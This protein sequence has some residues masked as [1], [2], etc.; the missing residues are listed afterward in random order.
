MTITSPKHSSNR[1]FSMIELLVTLTVVGIL[2]AVALPNL[3]DMVKSNAVAAQSNHFSTTIN[4]ARSEAVKRNLN[5]FIC[6]RDGSACTT[7][8]EWEDGWIVFADING[9]NALDAGEE[10]SLIDGLTTNYTL[11]SSVTSLDWLAF[12]SDGRAQSNASVF[13][14]V[15]FTL[16]PPGPA[17][18]P[19][20][21]RIITM[22]SV[23]RTS[24]AKGKV[25]D[26]CP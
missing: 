16:C 15:N 11:R 19:T 9:N 22:N 24:L 7:S 3:S 6:V 26:T 20:D 25:T 13:T 8:G 18:N 23:G 10:I 4:L 17:A 21:A 1:G 12:G 2:M 5:V 14:G